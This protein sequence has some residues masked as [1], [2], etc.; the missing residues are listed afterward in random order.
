LFILKEGRVRLYTISPEGRELTIATLEEGAVFGEMTLLGQE[1]HRN[2]A[3]AESPCLLYL[4]SREDVK[5]L[6]LGDPRIAARITEML[7]QRLM[8][9]ER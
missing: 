9:A 1:M 3:Q 6:L 4:M 7:G 2:F 8:T 5:T